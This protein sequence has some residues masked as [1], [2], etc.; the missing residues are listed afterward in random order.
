MSL[1]E[2]NNRPESEETFTDPTIDLAADESAEA[3]GDESEESETE[4]EVEGDDA[5][6]ACA[7]AASDEE[8]V[9][10]YIDRLQRMQA[11]FENFRRRSQ[12]ELREREERVTARVF[13]SVLTVVDDLRNAAQAEESRGDGVSEGLKIILDKVTH[14]LGEFSIEEIPAVGEPFDPMVHEAMIHQESDEVASGSILQELERGYRLKETL[15]RPARV[16]VAKG[17]DA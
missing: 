14:V 16:I 2:D 17:K 8:S 7:D 5:D 6:E 9:A 1:S 15:I 3:V 4:V 11:E 10:Y 12:Q 13:R